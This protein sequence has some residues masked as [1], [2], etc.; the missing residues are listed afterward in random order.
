MHI[1][2]A[3][4][5]KLNKQ[6]YMCVDKGFLSFI[7]CFYTA[8]PTTPPGEVLLRPPFFVP[9]PQMRLKICNATQSGNKNTQ[10]INTCTHKYLFTFENKCCK[11][12]FRSFVRG[13]TADSF[14]IY[15]LSFSELT[16]NNFIVDF[17]Q[18]KIMSARIKIVFYINSYATLSTTV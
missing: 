3:L 9:S 8:K 15:L 7:Y 6:M 16:T 14:D 1:L 5:I 17:I 10:Y 2:W 4:K 13:R 18:I 11:N 12:I